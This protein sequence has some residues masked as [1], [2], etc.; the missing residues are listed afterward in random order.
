MM[1][2]MTELSEICLL[3]YIFSQQD[4]PGNIDYRWVW[5]YLDRQAS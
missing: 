5:Y 3:D 2:W 1:F 4:R